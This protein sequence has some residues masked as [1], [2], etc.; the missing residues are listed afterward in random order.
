ME[1]TRDRVIERLA[2]IEARG[3]I[4][5]PESMF[6]RDDGI[7]GQILER[8]FEVPENNL[9]M[10]DLGTYELKGMRYKKN[11]SAML[12]LFHQ[13]PCSGMTPFELFDRF[14][15]VKPSRR[16]G[17][18]SKKLFTTIRGDRMNSMGFILVSPSE[19]EVCLYRGN[20]FLSAWDLSEAR[21]KIERVILA[22]AE[23]QG[24]T[25]SK[26]ECFHYIK[27]FL[28]SDVKNLSEAISCGAAV[29]DLCID[30]PLGSSRLP[31]DRG[32]HLRIPLKKLDCLY[33]SIEQLL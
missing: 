27:A 11:R 18:L 22:L 6:R 15:Y 8:E 3:F 23:T 2:E 13:K 12:T 7:V 16:N 4:P 21:A 19:N 28:L 31:H 24:A 9:H 30:Q 1:W 20:E 25:N 10:A 26:N 5:V 32:P 33:G 14:G 29:M 17:N